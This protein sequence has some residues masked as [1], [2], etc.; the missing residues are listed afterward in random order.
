MALPT[1][2]GAQINPDVNTFEAWLER[3]NE[4]ITDMGSRIVT[5][6]TSDNVGNTFIEGVFSANTIT[7]PGELRGGTIDT[8][9]A[10]T[11]SSNTIFS[12]NTLTIGPSV[13]STFNGDVLLTGA[14]RSFTVNNAV[15]TIS[16]AQ[17]N[18]PANTSFS[19]TVNFSALVTTQDLTVNGILT[20][21]NLNL[22]GAPLFNSLEVTG[23]SSFSDIT[24]SANTSANNIT[25]T[26]VTVSANT[27]LSRLTV[28]G[29]AVLST[30]NTVNINVSNTAN[31]ST[32]IVTNNTTMNVATISVL[33]SNNVTANN[34]TTNNLTSTNTTTTNLTIS[35]TGATRISTG[36]QTLRPVSPV[37]GMIR[38]NTTAPARF[39]GYDGTEWLTISDTLLTVSGSGII[40]KTGSGE[41]VARTISEGNGIAVTNGS[42][43]DGNPSIAVRFASNSE[44]FAG[45]ANRVISSSNIYTAN[46]P[47]AV[48]NYASALN[49]DTG[50]N[51]SGT[52]TANITIPNP[53]NQRAGQSGMIILKQ[54]GVG[55][56]T[57]TWASNW[58]FSGGITALTSAPNSIDVVSYYV[59][60]SGTVLCTITRGF[61]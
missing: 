34:F 30:A 44:M 54:D 39:E 46:A 35:G 31:I 36:A 21:T 40:V 51:F 22:L 59:E 56:R 47:V 25:A 37:A 32:L 14:S 4:I 26:N 29:N 13:S 11:I 20:A 28:S 53:T 3:T 19:N 6:T 23:G 41:G 16:S 18:I 61:G 45:A 17:L 5:L 8:P 50:R 58:K 2:V 12:A 27:T 48:A 15:T 42:G 38:F 33:S 60:S 55:G 57:A 52:L 10:L 7:I 49:L 24:V 43:I 9:S 1:Y